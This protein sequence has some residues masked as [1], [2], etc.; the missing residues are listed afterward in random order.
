M[1]DLKITPIT[2]SSGPTDTQPMCI[3]TRKRQMSLV[4]SYT[5]DRSIKR[6]EKMERGSLGIAMEISTLV[7]GRVAGKQMVRSISSK[8]MAHTVSAR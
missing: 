3:Q 2:Q 8:L 4:G 6:E 1:E 7:S 5:Q